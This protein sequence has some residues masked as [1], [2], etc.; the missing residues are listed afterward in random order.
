MYHPIHEPIQVLVSFCGDKI[1]PLFFHWAQRR[2]K[3]KKVHLIH[4]ERQ[5]NTKLFHFSVT[6]DV[7]YFK[8]TFNSENLQWILSE[9]YNEQS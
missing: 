3:V 1:Y 8:L 4:I 6:D 2:Y 5:G 7:N 9:V